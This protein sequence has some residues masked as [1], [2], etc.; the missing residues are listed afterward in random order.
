MTT[1]APALPRLTARLALVLAGLRVAA[2]PFQSGPILQ[3]P[4]PFLLWD[5]TLTLRTG[6]GYKENVLL[7][8]TQRQDSGLAILGAEWTIIRPPVDAN[9]LFF[10][11]SAD[12]R[13]Y[14]NAAVTGA[15]QPVA[16]QEQFYATH[17]TY[18]RTLS[19]HF[20]AG[21]G[22]THLYT[23][24]FLDA[25][26]YGGDPGS[27]QVVGHGLI[28]NPTLRA[29]LPAGLY[30]ELGTPVT[31][32][33]LR[34][35]V[36][37]YTEWG[38]RLA[39]G[40]T[41]STNGSVEASFAH[42]RRPFDTREQADPLGVPIAGT[43][44]ATRDLRT[45]LAWKQTW[46]AGRRVQTTTRLF[47][48]R[49]NDNGEGFTDYDRFGAAGTVKFESPRW[50][51]RGTARWTTYDFRGQIVSVFDPSLRTREGFEFEARLEYRWTSRFRTYAEFYH[52]QQRSNVPADDLHGHVW[53][54]G[55]ER[56]F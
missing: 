54:V 52:E 6:G 19:D 35:P 50:M 37:S 21:I 40:W 12:Q 1:P 24:Q 41:Y 53:Q 43:R 47:H 28:V 22:L 3:E 18:K 55:I 36:S 16:T 30:L 29:T 7:A 4:G 42:T 45:E 5:S 33:V 27:V 17:V 9:S 46:D 25:S 48:V 11:F 8:A 2:G 26:E 15:G 13:Y 38:P 14:L 31:R 51:L 23:Q 20:T 49:R 39:A 44:L 56:D 10:Y 32:Q 34:E